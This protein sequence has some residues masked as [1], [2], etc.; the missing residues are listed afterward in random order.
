[1]ATNTVGRTDD[2]RYLEADHVK[3]RAGSLAGFRVCTEDA[4]PIG[5]VRGVLINPAERRVAFL[6]LDAP[7]LFK[8]KRY[9]LPFDAGAV[10]APDPKTL[11]VAGRRDELDL[12]TFSPK[13]VEEFS[14]DDLLTTMFSSRTSHQV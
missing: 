14:D 7:G 5:H 9:L 6:V 10:V 13:S 3:C 11:Q 1:M 4:Q 12:E 2:L 8:S